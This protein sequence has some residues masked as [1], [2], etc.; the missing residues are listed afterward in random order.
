MTR[1]RI[2]LVLAGLVAADLRAWESPPAERA[3]LTLDRIFAAKDFEE[4]TPGLVFWS[5]RAPA[6]YTL[7]ES[8]N[9]AE[10]DLVRHDPVNRTAKAIVLSNEFIPLG[11]TKPLKVESFQFSAD[12]SK[13]LI[14]TNSQRVWR[15]RTRGD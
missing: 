2:A 15:H 6:Y 12:E 11:A 10:V 13:L 5:K 9:A 3:N 4:E 7:A 8:K 1:T 14:F